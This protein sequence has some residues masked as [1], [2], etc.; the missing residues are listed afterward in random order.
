MPDSEDLDLL[1]AAAH[2]AAEIALRHW[3]TG[4]KVWDKGSGLG[5]VSE[6]DLEVDRH[7]RQALLAERPGYGWLS[8][9]GEA[10]PDRLSAERVFI[11]DPIDGTRNYLEGEDSWAISLAVAGAGRVEA[12]VVL[13]PARDRLYAAVRGGGATR[14]GAGIRASRRTEIGD[15]NVL[16]PRTA[17]TADAWRGAPVP[18]VRRHFRPSLAYRLCLVAEGR[19][20]A[21]MTFRDCWEWDIAAGALIAEEAGATASDRT[22]APLRFNT[23]FARTPGAVV[24]PAALHRD[25][26]LPPQA[27]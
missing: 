9:E 11:I 5:P 24:A 4:P 2:S 27:R 16:A 1:T 22:G 8:E 6:A 3:R 10:D 17:L 19:F 20:D 15:A 26:I 21:M 14:D 23:E 25:L 12:G 18:Q 7:L 13:M